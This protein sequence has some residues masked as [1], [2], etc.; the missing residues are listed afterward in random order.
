M[1]TTTMQLPGAAYYDTQMSMHTA[2][3]N[4]Y[5]SLAREFQR[6]LSDPTWT[7]CWLDHGKDR[8]YSSKLKG[9][10]SEYHA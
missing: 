10:E 3:M 6:H 1:L 4:T 2:T 9:T 7:P 5:I 8:E